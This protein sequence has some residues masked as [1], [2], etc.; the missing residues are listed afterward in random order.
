[1]TTY[2]ETFEKKKLPPCL[3]TPNCVSSQASDKPHYILPFKISGDPNLA[4]AELKKMITAHERMIIT[5]ETEDTLH[6]EARSLVLQFVDDI[7]AILDTDAG[8]IHIRSASR[9]GHS[10]FGVNRKRM[11]KFR[12]QLRKFHFLEK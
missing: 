8:L 6:A 7:D 3:D 12:L 5:H 10:D 9:V 1:M 4:W 11:E 2:A